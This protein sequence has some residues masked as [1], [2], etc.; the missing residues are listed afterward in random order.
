M[1]IISIIGMRS[2]YINWMIRP[3]L[4]LQGL[5]G[6]IALNQPKVK[7]YEHYKTLF[8]GDFYLDIKRIPRGATRGIQYI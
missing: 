8:K 7:K 6:N 1:F 5:R 2:A 3:F 4:N